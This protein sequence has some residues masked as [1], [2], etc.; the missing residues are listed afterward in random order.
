M[1]SGLPDTVVIVDEKNTERLRVIPPPP[2][3]STVRL[4]ETVTHRVASA[5]CRFCVFIEVAAPTWIKKLAAVSILT[6]STLAGKPVESKPEHSLAR[7]R[8]NRTDWIMLRHHY[9][10]HTGTLAVYYRYYYC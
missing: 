9:E 4:N 3:P 8:S 6:R 2:V 5:F 1:A 7:I 10:W